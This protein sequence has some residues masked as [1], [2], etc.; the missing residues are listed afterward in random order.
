VRPFIYRP[1]LPRAIEAAPVDWPAL[2]VE[3]EALEER[4][5]PYLE[6]IRR[7]TNAEPGGI[8]VFAFSH[9]G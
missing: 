2:V 3:A 1:G 6:A 9:S 4:R 8:F 7:Y 5:F